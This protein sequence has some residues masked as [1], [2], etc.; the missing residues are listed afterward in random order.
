MT[1]V[2]LLLAQIQA[3]L[4]L[5]RDTEQDLLEEIRVHLEEAVEGALE[6]GMS[7]E[8][9]LSQVAT[10]FGVGQEVG[11]ALQETHLGW[12]TAEAVVAAGLPVLLSLILRWVLFS[13]DGT[14]IGWQQVLVRPSFWL[15][16]LVAL[17]VP[18]VRFHRWRFALVSWSIFWLMTVLFA[19]L[20]VLHW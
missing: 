20:P 3:E 4:D 7:R 1:D 14:A 18:L 11:L 2:E 19:L 15:V 10:R 16:S 5:D 13:P 8:Q 17:L 9:A 6:S 12:G